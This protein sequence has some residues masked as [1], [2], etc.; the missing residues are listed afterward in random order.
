MNLFQQ[1][2]GVALVTALL[3]VTIAVVI[4]AELVDQL[5]YDTRRTENMIHNEQA[6]LYSIEAEN[7]AIQTLQD[8]RTQNNYDN[9]TDTWA[10]ATI[11]ALTD[12]PLVL[13]IEGGEVSGEIRDLQSRF[14]LNNMSKQLNTNYQQSVTQFRRLLQ[15]L[16]IN[17]GLADGVVDWLDTGI[18]VEPTAYG[19]EDDYYIGLLK[20]YR[21]A[22]GLMASASE[23]RMVKGFNEEAN[24]D[25][26]VNYIVALPQVTAINVNTA[27]A[28]VLESLSD[29]I[30]ASEADE[31]IKRTGAN[32]IFDTINS[33]NNQASA[34]LNLNDMASLDP[35]ESIN[36]FQSHMKELDK[37]NFT[38][39]NTMSISS[40]YFQLQS[41]TKVGRG[42][43]TL[44]STIQR[45][46]SGSRVI[47]RS[48]GAW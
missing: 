21:A 46:T 11:A 45:S 9:F 28:K 19:A 47:Q 25:K 26:L 41:F 27:P 22:N 44:Y 23:L 6:Y 32:I 8:D 10:E 17:T 31:I 15:A 29:D 37:K 20:P 5:H 36:D 14:N 3:V 39:D 38:A 40:D 48:Q 18:E 16:G 7:I 43:V 1:Q 33:S 42:Q 13:P 24:Y 4:A 12:E 2:K 30:T 35:Y 34:S